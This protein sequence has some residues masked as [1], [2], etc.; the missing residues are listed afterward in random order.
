MGREKR[1][2]ARKGPDTENERGLDI[3]RLRVGRKDFL[4][5]MTYLCH[6]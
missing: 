2:W 3:T 4:Y 1:S 5:P 6:V